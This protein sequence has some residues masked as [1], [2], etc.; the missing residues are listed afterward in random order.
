MYMKNKR[1]PEGTNSLKKGLSVLSCFTWENTSLTLTEIARCLDLPMPTASRIA[2]ALEEEG[3]LER[4]RNTKA[5]HL[6]FKCYLFGSMAKKTGGLRNLV[7]PYMQDL[8]ERF[9]ETVNF[10]V[11]EGFMR[12]CYEQVESSWDLKRTAKLGAKF[13]LWAGAAGRC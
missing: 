7:L 8:K 12:T 11:R 5:Y 3:F 2:R 1:S 6:G 13:T 9:N 10:Y 4:D